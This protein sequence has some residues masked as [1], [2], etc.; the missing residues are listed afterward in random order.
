MMDVVQYESDFYSV[1]LIMFEMMT[2][3]KVRIW[4]MIGYFGEYQ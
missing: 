4:V 3:R 1:G 2:Q